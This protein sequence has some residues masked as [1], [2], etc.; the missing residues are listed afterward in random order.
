MKDR[1]E[2]PGCLK[3]LS[4]LRHKTADCRAGNHHENIDGDAHRQQ[5][6]VSVWSVDERYETGDG[7]YGA[8]H[9]IALAPSAQKRECVGEDSKKWFEVPCK[10]EPKEKGRCRSAVFVQFVLQE[11]FE[12]D[13]ADGV[14]L[15]ES[16]RG[17][18]EK[19]DDEGVQQ[20]SLA[21]FRVRAIRRPGVGLGE[22]CGQWFF[23]SARVLALRTPSLTPALAKAYKH[24]PLRHLLSTVEGHLFETF[25]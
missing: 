7:E 8:R 20:F 2:P 12:R 14:L 17:N 10:A 11:I 1:R 5:V 23:V 25:W 21:F 24:L 18:P 3:R 22:F 19:N 15:A 16:D 13:Q 4:L 6:G 9:D